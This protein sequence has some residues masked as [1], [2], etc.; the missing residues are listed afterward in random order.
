MTAPAPTRCGARRLV[1][2]G[3][4]LIMGIVNVTPDSFS[5]D[6]LGDDAARAVAHGLALAR[7]GADLLDVG[8]ESTRPGATPV[9][10][11]EEQRRVLPVIERLAAEA[12]VP[13]SIDTYRAVTAAAALRAGATMVNDVWGL[14]H[15]PA[16]ASVVAAAGAAVVVMHNR[17]TPPLVSPGVGGH[18]A[19]A[20]YGGD[21]VAD[22]LAWLS[23]SLALAD[24]AGIDP[25][26]VIVDPGIGFGKGLEQNLEVIRR[27]AAFRV[28]GRP[29]LL[30]AS[31][32]SFL[33]RLLGGLPPAERGE[34]TAAAVA[35]GI[36]HGADIVRVH[37]VRAMARVARVAD[38]IVRGPPALPEP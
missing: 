17:T 16:M 14:R 28:L 12:G 24:D 6:G 20:D 32:K 7:D 2:G 9:S 3:R 11:A 8:G 34:A 38:A 18:F 29:V 37:D 27:L 25:A 26:Q 4:T 31:R 5:G 13:V 15:D 23:D 19:A 35:L 36:A 21:L 33:G 30:G 10:P 1:W 22:V